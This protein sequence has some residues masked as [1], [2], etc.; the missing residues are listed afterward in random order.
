MRICLGRSTSCFICGFVFQVI[1]KNHC[2]A[3]IIQG[4]RQTLLNKNNC[5][6]NCHKFSCKFFFI[7]FLSCRRN[8]KKRVKFSSSWWSDDEK[9]FFLFCLSWV[10]LYFKAMPNSIDFFKRIW[11]H[12]IPARIIVPCLLAK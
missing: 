5:T 8:K 3:K 4:I 10:A 12:V 6:Y 7:F 2:I 9:Y 1:V 11:L